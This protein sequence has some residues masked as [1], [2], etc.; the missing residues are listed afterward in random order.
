MGV[1]LL[2]PASERYTRTEQSTLGRLHPDPNLGPSNPSTL[3]L[4]PLPDPPDAPNPG[5]RRVESAGLMQSHPLPHF[6]LG[7]QK[8]LS[9]TERPLVLHALCT[10]LVI[11]P[12]RDAQARTTSNFGVKPQ[13]VVA[14][15]LPQ[16]LRYACGWRGGG[17]SLRA[18]SRFRRVD[19]IVVDGR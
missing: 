2:Q 13:A 7:I 11:M 3:H 4:H 9:T 12:R 19:R 18:G 15:V 16:L 14:Q 5:Q 1:E 8:I 17:M 10:R 6:F